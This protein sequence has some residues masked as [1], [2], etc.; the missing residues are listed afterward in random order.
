MSE[1]M[2]R[3]VDVA[4]EKLLVGEELTEQ[5]EVLVAYAWTTAGCASCGASH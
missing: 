5:E 3:R 2:R 4:V 1:E